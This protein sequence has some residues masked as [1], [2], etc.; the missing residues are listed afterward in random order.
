MC[1]CDSDAV[2]STDRAAPV[3]DQVQHLIR[4]VSRC[5][6]SVQDIEMQV[7]FCEMAEVDDSRLRREVVHQH[8]DFGGGTR[9][10]GERQRDVKLQWNAIVVDGDRHVV[11]EFDQVGAGIGIGGN[12]R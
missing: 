1:L 2:F 7:A 10:Y 8:L 9:E 6:A 11:T 3:D 5:V 4:D 12:R